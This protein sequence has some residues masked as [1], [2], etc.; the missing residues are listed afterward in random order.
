MF[1]HPLNLFPNALVIRRGKQPNKLQENGVMNPTVHLWI[2]SLCEGLYKVFSLL[3]YLHFLGRAQ[4]RH[5]SVSEAKRCC[6]RCPRLDSSS[7]IVRWS[8]DHIWLAAASTSVCL[9]CIFISRHIY[10]DAF[11]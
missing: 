3:F 6:L 10:L 11:L 4:I 8:E 5:S 1:T 7:K 9:D 2:T